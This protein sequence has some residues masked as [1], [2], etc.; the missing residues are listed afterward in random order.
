[1]DFYCADNQS[2][3]QKD[4]VTY[5]GAEFGTRF[6]PGQWGAEFHSPK[7]GGGVCTKVQMGGEVHEGTGG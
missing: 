5:E 2:I 7:G 6:V 3:V 1:M 4:N